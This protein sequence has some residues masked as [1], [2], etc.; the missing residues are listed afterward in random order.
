MTR[1]WRIL[2]LSLFILSI[3]TQ[4]IQNENQEVNAVGNEI[5][6]DPTDYPTEQPIPDPTSISEKQ[7]KLFP[8]ENDKISSKE[9]EAEI[10][11]DNPHGH[12]A[13]VTLIIITA[14]LLFVILSLLCYK[15]C[16]KAK[17]KKQGYT[18]SAQED[19]VDISDGFH[20]QQ[21]GINFYG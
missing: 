6:S 4:T 10:R 2:I 9:I 8:D 21:N 7:Q 15:W 18:L 12:L 5:T 3:P 19:S 16:I 20:P 14:I 1:W 13:I 11:R 17:A